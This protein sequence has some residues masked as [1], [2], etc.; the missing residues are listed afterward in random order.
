[1]LSNQIQIEQ[2]QTALEATTFKVSDL[3]EK[4]QQCLKIFHSDIQKT[5]ALGNSEVLNE[6]LNY[7]LIFPVDI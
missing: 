7:F 2:V 3:R 4:F 1:M 6:I 5:T